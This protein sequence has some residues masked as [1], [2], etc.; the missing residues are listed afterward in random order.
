MTTDQMVKACLNHHFF[1]HAER[2][3]TLTQELNPLLLLKI[4]I[5]RY[6]INTEFTAM[7][8]RHQKNGSEASGI[9]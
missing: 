6:E 8:L 4:E 7:A 1:A 3:N 2:L 9:G 5:K